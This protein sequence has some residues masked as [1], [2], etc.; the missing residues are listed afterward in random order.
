MG[1][2]IVS[3]IG[4]WGIG[5]EERSGKEICFRDG[6]GLFLLGIRSGPRERVGLVSFLSLEVG[7]LGGGELSCLLCV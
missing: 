2:R 1:K 4:L 3:G 5:W 7:L 6:L